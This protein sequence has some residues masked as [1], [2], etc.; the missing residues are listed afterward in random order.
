MV[1][2]VFSQ[3]IRDSVFQIEGV[4]VAA[5]RIFVKEQAGMK[6]SHVDSTVLQ[7]KAILS[8]S[9][10]LSENTSVFIKN[11]GRG[12]LATASFRGTSASHT[13]VTWN[14]IS[15]NSPMTGMTDFSLIPVYVVDEV[16]LKH[17]T[18]SISEMNGG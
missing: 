6:Q 7:N 18:G 16:N 13:Q 2:P 12:A 3:G 15:I 17:G 11:H 9:E 4:S 10:L 5:Q 8:L 1:Y 14:G